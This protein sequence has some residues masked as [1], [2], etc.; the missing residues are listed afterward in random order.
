MRALLVALLLITTPCAAAGRSFLV[1]A[2]GIGGEPIYSERFDT[3]SRSMLEAAETRMAIPRDRIVF[4]SETL[5]DGV[6]ALSTKSALQASIDGLATMAEPGDTI[7]LLLIGHG[8]ARGDR[9][10]FNL[11]GPDVSAEE[12]DAMLAP[13]EGLRW[14]IVNT[15]PSSGPFI[16]ALSGPNRVVV[17]ATASAMERYHT[18]FPHHFV[19]AYAEEGADTDKNGRISVTEAFEFARREVERRYNEEGRLQSEH[20]VLDDSGGLA[21]AAYLESDRALYAPGIPAQALERLLAE[22]DILEQ[23]IEFLKTEKALL[24]PVLYD[25]RLEALLIEFALVHRALRAPEATQ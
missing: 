16:D 11:P 9:F 14:V 3:W 1:I 18:V 12:L 6:N 25:D 20:A 8:T 15:A 24:D 7:F 5:S 21:G 4:L 10:L 17:T 19:A 2:S 23:R 13:H 22:R